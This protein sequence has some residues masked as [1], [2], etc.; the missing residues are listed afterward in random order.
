MRA[1]TTTPVG[2]PA[3]IRSDLL[4]TA[5]FPVIVAGRFLHRHFEACSVFTLHCGPHGSLISRRDLF[6]EYF[7]PLVTSRSCPQCFGLER[8]CPPGI[9]PGELLC[10]IMAYTTTSPRTP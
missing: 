1:A 8:R 2:S 10:L 7:S 3:A 5:T 4:V 9:S 6:W